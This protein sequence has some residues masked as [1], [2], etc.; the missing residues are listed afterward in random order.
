MPWERMDRGTPETPV[1][2]SEERVCG[3]WLP[4]GEAPHAR[5]DFPRCLFHFSI[6]TSPSGA[7]SRRHLS[8]SV[9]LRLWSC[10]VLGST[11]ALPG[12][13]LGFLLV[14]SPLLGTQEQRDPAAQARRGARDTG[15]GWLLLSFQEKLLLL[16]SLQVVLADFPC[17][18]HGGC[19]GE[20]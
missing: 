4:K 19:A 20:D 1:R 11:M 14:L 3:C 17:L 2:V 7:R 8:P 15:K 12:L 18:A 13:A 10:P 9:G 5:H 16:V 6:C